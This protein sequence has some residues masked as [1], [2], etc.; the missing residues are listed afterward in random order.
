M[1]RSF[2]E[3]FGEEY[4]SIRVGLSA[5]SFGNVTSGIFWERRVVCVDAGIS[6]REER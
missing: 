5:Y 3:G 4:I 2:W 1:Y 6:G